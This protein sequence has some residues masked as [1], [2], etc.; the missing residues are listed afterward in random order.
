[1]NRIVLLVLSLFSLLAVADDSGIDQLNRFIH[2]SA[3]LSA[4]F[5]QV[6]LDKAGRPGQTSSGQFYLSRPGKFRWNY[7]KPFLQEI[8]ANAGKVW[9]YDVDLEQVTRKQLDDSLG[10]TPALLLTGEVNLQEKFRLDEQGQDG[11]MRWV[12]LSPKN[13]ES[14]FKSILIGLNNGQLSGMEL[15][16]NFGQLTRIYFSNIKINPSLP[17]KLFEFVAPKGVDVL[18]N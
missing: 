9:F 5:K 1:M 16:D 15:S 14:G 10:S 8:V 12:K 2:S 17:D 13:D 4:D 3:S 7:Q 18:Q 6:S 11:E